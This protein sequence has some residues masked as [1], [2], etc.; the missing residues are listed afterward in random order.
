M[1]T[2]FMKNSLEPTFTTKFSRSKRKLKMPFTGR[3]FSMLMDCAP[4]NCWKVRVRGRLKRQ[5]CVMRRA[6]MEIIKRLI[7]V[8]AG[9]FV[10]N[11]TQT[12]EN[13]RM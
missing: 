12:L 11:R 9:S 8:V 10:C 3:S 5:K 7:S 13:V 1:Y 2:R 6:R 4:A